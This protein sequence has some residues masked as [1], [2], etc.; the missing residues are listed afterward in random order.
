M[1][2]QTFIKGTMIL[3]AAGIFTRILGFIPRILLPRIIGAEGIGLYQLGYPLLIL[4]LTLI[5]GG[6]PLSVAKLTAE[7]ESEGNPHKM[8][9]LLYVSLA[10]VIPMALIF[11]LLIIW[12]APWVSSFLLKD[13]RVYLTLIAMSPIVLIVS[14]SSVFRGYFQGRHNM[15][16][17]ALSTSVETIIR[18]FTMLLIS[19]W[20][21]PYGLEKAAAG[22][23]IGVFIGEVTGLLVLFFQ[24]RGQHRLGKSRFR[25]QR[26]SKWNTFRRMMSISIPV[27]SSKLIGSASYFLESIMIVQSLAIVGISSSQATAMYGILTGMV[28]PILLLPTALTY[29]LSVS[30]VPSLSEAAAKGDDHMIRKRIVQSLRIA[31]V[32]GVPFMVIMLL[33]SEPL[34]MLLYNDTQPAH[35]LK[36]LAPFAVFI[37]LQAPLQAALQ[38]LDRPGTALLNTFVG[39]TVKLVLIYLLAAKFSMGMKGAIFALSINMVLVT[40]L[41]WKSIADATQFKMKLSDIVNVCIGAIVMAVGIMGLT[42]WNPLSNPSVQFLMTC[43]IGVAVYLYMM[44]MLGMIDRSDLVR[45][46][47]IGRLFQ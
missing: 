25:K 40:L 37:Y 35:M 20:L 19:Y 22:A 44:L 12:S 1:T 32:T 14:V 24:Y 15:I 36:W 16:P 31:L 18:C 34:C 6:I 9:V 8:K 39:A 41:H 13:E 5:T 3:L 11:S 33:L 23:M 38:A 42:M 26:L 45:I 21:L 7:A 30:L 27:T 43:S 10:F 17:S 29:S 46:P 2:R 47:W 28:I 4:I